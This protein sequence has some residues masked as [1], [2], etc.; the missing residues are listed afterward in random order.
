MLIN[1]DVRPEIEDFHPIPIWMRQKSTPCGVYPTRGLPFWRLCETR[2]SSG[3]RKLDERPQAPVA[4][5]PWSP[6]DVLSTPSFFSRR[7]YPFSSTRLY[8][9]EDTASGMAMERKTRWQELDLVPLVLAASN[10]LDEAFDELCHRY[11]GAIRG[12]VY[13][14]L[15]DRELAADVLQD[16]LLIAYRSLH[17]LDKPASFPNWLYTIARHRANHTLRVRKKLH[18]VPLREDEPGIIAA[19]GMDED[20]AATLDR[21]EAISRLHREL[22]HL[23]QDYRIVLELRYWRELKIRE[24]GEV[25]GVPETTVKWRLHKAKELLFCTMTRV[26]RKETADENN[27]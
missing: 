4:N 2:L 16:S 12:T 3:I 15:G 1:A 26:G 8:I 20:L 5:H 27:G 24:I 18:L 22:H 19:A 7:H 13:S 25:L 14:I 10:G 17:Q 11:A 9:S 6:V 21:V 23:P